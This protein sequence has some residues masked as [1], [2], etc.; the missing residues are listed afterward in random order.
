MLFGDR[1]DW[2]GMRCLS[3]RLRGRGKRSE[4]VQSRAGQTEM[5]DSTTGG[6]GAEN[7]EAWRV[8]TARQGLMSQP[9]EVEQEPTR[10]VAGGVDQ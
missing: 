5:V 9:G 10:Q 7:S 2:G 6:D 3:A 8:N 4:A 1:L